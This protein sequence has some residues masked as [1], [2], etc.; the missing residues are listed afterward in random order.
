MNRI[1]KFNQTDNSKWYV[2]TDTH[3]GH[4]RDFIVG[5]RG[6][7]NITDHDN[8][9]IDKINEIVRPND[10]L[11]HLGDWCLNTTRSQFEEQLSRIKCQNIYML[12][13]NHNNPVWSV[14][15]EAIADELYK[16]E[17]RDGFG[18]DATIEIYPFKYR[19]VTFL[20]N[21]AEMSVDGHYFVCA[22]Y[23]IFVFNE[24][25]H[26]AKHLCGHSHYSLELS[27][28]DNLQSKI[29]DCGWDGHAKPLSLNEVLAI[30]AK[31]G[32]LE[33]DHHQKGK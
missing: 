32:T 2:T 25:N 15:Q 10:T 27:Q 12:W 13:G 16:Y 31:K 21:Y 14:Y 28:S 18:M 3:L 6:Y 33:V 24:M 5:A 11:V 9:V 1:L 29:L 7:K 17:T 26:G 23:P 19:N 22:H 20:G 4:N 30:M 8:A